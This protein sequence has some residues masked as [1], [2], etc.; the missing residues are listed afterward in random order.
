LA[1]VVLNTATARGTEGNSYFG[2]AIGFTV[3]TGAYAVGG[4]TGG[5]FNPA[6]AV[7]LVAL[8]ILPAADLGPHFI[9]QFAAGAAA[10]LVFRT[11]D[12]G[13]DKPTTATRAEQAGLD[14]PASTG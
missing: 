4:I 8:G 14:K 11:L 7:G 5:A 6:V 3:A 2:L 1:F 12:L 10:A 9:A 13:E